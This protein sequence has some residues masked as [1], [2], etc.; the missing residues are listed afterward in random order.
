MSLML[1]LATLLAAAA[2]AGATH[3]DAATAGQRIA[4]PVPSAAGPKR[5]GAA[6]VSASLDGARLSLT[7]DAT[8]LALPEARA[9]LAP[10]FD[11]DADAAKRASDAQR[12]AVPPAEDLLLPKAR[13][14]TA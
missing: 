11:V 6:G 9:D 1:R 14:V 8:A 4:L 3:A 2:V 13:H 10:A 12:D 7:F 5:R